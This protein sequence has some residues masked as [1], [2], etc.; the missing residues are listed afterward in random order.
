MSFLKDH[1]G[2][3]FSSFNADLFLSGKF[4]GKV[5]PVEWDSPMTPNLVLFGNLP[6]NVATPFL[7]KL[8]RNMSDQS[9]IYSFGRV[10]AVLSFQHEVAA[11]MIAAPEQDTRCRLSVIVQNW[12]EVE[13][14][15]TL[16][17]G[18]FVPPPD[19]DVG[20]VK[21]VPH[22]Q[23]YIQLPY[24]LVD[25][26]IS[27]LF[28]SGK[29]K[30]IVSNLKRLFSSQGISS[31]PDCLNL[32]NELLKRCDIEPQKSAVN[33][34]MQEIKSICFTY[35]LMKE[36]HPALSGL[37]DNQFEEESEAELFEVKTD[38]SNKIAVSD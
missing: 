10:P 21:L 35:Q 4:E 32:S 15:H 16:K 20:I 18:A 29:N 24:P 17:G 9:N 36:T 11:R 30:F 12:A 19:V 3:E 27:A 7:I 5:I 8:L 6:F 34:T 14:V 22:R 28:V 25:S 33:L 13:Y 1:G 26:V 23:P 38:I 2:H 37:K 31:P